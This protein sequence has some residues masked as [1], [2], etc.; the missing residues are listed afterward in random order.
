MLQSMTGFGRAEGRDKAH[1]LTV[2]LRS[3][4]H[5]YCDVVVRLPRLFSSLD[6]KLK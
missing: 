4:N 6:E 3:V 1:A 2:E 5:R